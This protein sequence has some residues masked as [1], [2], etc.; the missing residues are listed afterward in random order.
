MVGGV[1]SRSLVDHRMLSIL[2]FQGS[3]R[4][5]WHC[6]VPRR[7]RE[8]SPRNS[9]TFPVEQSPAVFLGEDWQYRQQPPHTRV[10]RQ[11]SLQWV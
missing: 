4:V 3:W 2:V 7:G 8:W 5:P 10:H 6:R 1:L 9:F 11:V